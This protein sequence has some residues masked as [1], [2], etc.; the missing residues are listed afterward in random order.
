MVEC[1]GMFVYLVALTL[2]L[3]LV[4]TVLFFVGI[5]PSV[6]SASSFDLIF[7]LARFAIVIYTGWIFAK[8]GLKTVAVK[9]SILVFA[10]VTLVFLAVPIGLYVQGN[11]ASIPPVSY[12]VIAWALSLLVNI[13]ISI[14]LAAIVAW[15][16]YAA[17]KPKA[18][19]GAEKIE[20]VRKAVTAHLAEPAKTVKKKAAR[21]KSKGKRSR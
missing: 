12:L 6:G 11:S 3:T 4:E 16:S 20:T 18:G 9:A 2:I 10:A 19:A 14:I 1:K 17:Q 7:V 15:I 13:V 21:K 5:L 8:H